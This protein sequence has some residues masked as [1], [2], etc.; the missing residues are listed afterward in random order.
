MLLRTGGYRRRGIS[1]LEVIVATTVFLMSLIGIRQL[2]SV[3]GDRALEVE[4]RS[5]AARLCRSKMA[6][7]QSGVL[8]MSSASD[9]FE[10][11]P[12]F[13]WS[14]D[15]EQGT[16]DNLWVATVK[17][18]RNQ[19]IGNPIE[20]SLSQMLIDPSIAGSTADAP[21]IAGTDTATGNPSSSSTTP[22]GGAAAAPMGGAA[23]T[24]PKSNMPA[25]PTGG[26]APKPTTPAPKP[27]MPAPAAPKTAPAPAPAAPKA[28][29]TPTPTKGKAG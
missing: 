26:A 5:Q 21:V 23:A 20:V 25:G 22:M 13:S 12:D 7:V 4:M 8:P 28:P 3:A 9:T 6:E 16:V 29:A 24:A 27:A 15:V 18:T 14:L 10:E 11:D 19:S 1:L 17:V 2:V